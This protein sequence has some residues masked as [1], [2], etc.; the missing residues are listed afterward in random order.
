MPVITDRNVLLRRQASGHGVQ[1]MYF[2]ST[3]GTTTAAAA[4]SGFLTAQLRWNN[5]GTS[6]PTTRQSLP[7]PAGLTGPVMANLAHSGMSAAVR[8]LYLAILYQIGT[9][10][11]AATGNQLT[12]HAATFP[13]LRTIFGVANTPVP[14]IPVLYLTA[15]TATTA[16]AFRLRTATDTAG[17]VNQDGT[18]VIGAKT[19]TMPA[20]ATAVQSA[21]I[22]RLEDGDSAVRDITQVRVDTA[23]SAGAGQL[24]GAELIAPLGY[25]VAGLSYSADLALS[26]LSL[27]NIRPGVAS[28]GT[29]AVEFAV[30]SLGATSAGN[31]VLTI[32]GSLDT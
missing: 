29:A 1:G 15:S 7:L 28:S 25:H 19:F 23:G 12:H 4:A 2:T 21:F 13:I 16:P 24:F 20:A 30:L 6:L 5:L 11:L 22:L 14:L 9:V 18:S 3:T 10:N 27:P 26:G 32:S 8:G 17:Y 31:T